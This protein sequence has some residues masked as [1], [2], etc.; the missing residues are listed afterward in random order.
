M[1]LNKTA[2]EQVPIPDSGQAFYRDD[3][4]K[5]FALRLT[6][7]GS[8]SFVVEKRINGKMKRQTLGRF[9][10]LTVEQAR[11]QAQKFLGE[12]ATGRDPISEKRVEQVK[13]VT[14]KEAFELYLKVRAGLKETTVK[15]RGYACVL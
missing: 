3:M 12:V 13:G 9:G 8:K 2:V 6:S 14:L 15:D 10:E 5:G 11:K 4:L 7:G 1:R